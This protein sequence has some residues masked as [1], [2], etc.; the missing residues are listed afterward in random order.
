MKAFLPFTACAKQSA[1]WW[2]FSTIKMGGYALGKA[3]IARFKNLT[4]R[5]TL[6]KRESVQISLYSLRLYSQSIF[7]VHHLA[8][9]DTVTRFKPANCYVS[10]FFSLSNILAFNFSSAK[11]SKTYIRMTGPPWHS[12]IVKQTQHSSFHRSSHYCSAQ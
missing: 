6:L 12:K 5:P 1:A 9:Q 4:I 8:W 2:F 7:V 11:S 3:W 10:P